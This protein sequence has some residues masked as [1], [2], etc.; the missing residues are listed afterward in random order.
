MADADLD[1]IIT[2]L[3]RKREQL[4]DMLDRLLIKRD[5]APEADESPRPP[6]PERPAREEP[7]A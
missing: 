6:E 7:P 3:R 5:D 1:R 4:T 2:D